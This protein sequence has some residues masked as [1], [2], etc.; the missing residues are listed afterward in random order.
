MNIVIVIPTYNEKDNI[1]P[2]VEKIC[3]VVPEIKILIV[4]DNSP[5]GT[6]RIADELNQ[7]YKQVKVLHREKKE[8]LGK[9][10][11][12]GF[13]EALKMNPDYILQMDADFSHHPKYIPFFLKEIS[14][15]DIVLGSR[16][17]VKKERPLNVTVFSLWANRYVQWITGM[18]V[19]DC[20][21]GFKCFRRT[22]VEE[23]GL[24]KFIS[25]GFIFQTEFIYRA[26][27]RGSSVHEIPIIFY[28]R[29]SG[30]SKKSKRI[31]LEALFKTI[32]FRLF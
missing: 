24:D 32:L 31:I 22:V 18:K 10:Y 7:R 2:L 19:R 21:G 1:Q 3:K 26:L 14:S 17:L 13:K 20:L 8:G 6:G 23:I 16:F 28:P 30:L 29:N 9:A 15:C 4:D 11:I 27:K 12:A 5:D 25:K